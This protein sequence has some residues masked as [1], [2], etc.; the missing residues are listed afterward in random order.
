MKLKTSCVIFS[1]LAFLFLTTETGRGQVVLYEEHF[2][3][4]TTDLV[5]ES[6]FFDSVG[7][8]LTPMQVESLP[9]NPSGDAWIGVVEADTAIIGG[10]GLATAGDESL[11]DYS[12]EAQIIVNVTD[13]S[14]YEGIMVRVNRDTTTGVVQGYQLVSNFYPMFGSTQLRFRKYSTIPNDIIVLRTWDETEIPGGAPTESG[15]HTF[16]I[17]AQGDLFWLYWDDMELPDNPQVDTTATPLLS[18]NFGVYIFN[19]GWGRTACDDIIVEG[20]PQGV[21]D[22]PDNIGLPRAFSLSQNYPNPFNPM[23]TIRVDI[24]AGDPRHS[25]LKIY[26]LRGRQIRT[27]AD[28]PLTQ[29]THLFAWDGRDDSGRQVSSGTYIYRMRQG[30]DQYTRKMLLMK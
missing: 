8:P 1:V 19:L 26:N 7:T 27:L 5:W 25:V 6:A 22:K 10:L 18:G 21:G 16:K 28:K 12:M 20:E 24:P 14:F 29:G 30:E 3:G 4:G 17:D 2:T 15:W 9:G 23:T 11:T 13:G